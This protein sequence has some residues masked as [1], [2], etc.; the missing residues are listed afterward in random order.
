MYCTGIHT[1]ILACGGREQV[2][3]G[4]GGGGGVLCDIPRR[5]KKEHI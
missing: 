4:G 3:A 5:K 2:H 1:E